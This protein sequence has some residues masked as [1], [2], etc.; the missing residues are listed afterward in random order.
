MLV[1]GDPVLGHNTDKAAD[2]CKHKA[3]AEQEFKRGS[4]GQAYNEYRHCLQVFGLAVPGSRLQCLLA[5]GWQFLR[6]GLHRLWVGRWLSRKAGGLFCAPQQRREALVSARE[7]A[8]VHHRLNQLHIVTNGD[9]LHGLYYSL[10]A[11]NMAEAADTQI[12]V[13]SL[14]EIYLMA[15]LRV[16][17][18][19]PRWLQYFCRYYVT[20]AKNEYLAT[21]VSNSSANVPAKFKWEFTPYGY[22]F[23]A[24]HPVQY[25]MAEGSSSSSTTTTAT[26]NNNDEIASSS[27]ASSSGGVT[28]ASLFSVLDNR[29]D[30]LAYVARTYR[31][32][33]LKRALQALVGCGRNQKYETQVVAG[34][35]DRQQ[36]HE[37][38]DEDENS[39][40]A[41]PSASSIVGTQI[42]DVL[43]YAQLLMESMGG[44][45]LDEDP[46]AVWWCNLVTVS[47]YW[48]LGDDEKAGRLYAA[49]ERM[50][51]ELRRNAKD[52][53]PAAILAAFR[54][55]RMFM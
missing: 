31:E 16:K 30:P 17:Q 40:L 3:Q 47:A 32:H 52:K 10:C 50:P 53:L 26:D 1:Y 13:D 46:L 29:S 35:K 27:D 28:A 8:L 54:A 12:A 15:A 22:H 2:Y 55:K 25:E 39:L 33:L 21:T 6:M 14:I 36:Q 7:I 24:T 11:V 38:R 18:T 41:S 49:I 9:G 19:Y 44:G 20:K 45:K 34:T 4:Y 43:C 23:F 51:E 37:R 42:F 48:L 5:I